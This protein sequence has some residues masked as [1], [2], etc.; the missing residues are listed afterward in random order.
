MLPDQSQIYSLTRRITWVLI[1]AMGCALGISYWAAGLSIDTSGAGYALITIAVLL[2]ISLYYRKFRVDAF[3]STGAEASFQLTAILGMGT[4]LTFAAAAVG[5]PYRDTVLTEVDRSMG[6]NWRAYLDFFNTHYVI[7]HILHVIYLSIHFQPLLVVG[8]L[9]ATRRFLR[10]RQFILAM[11]V[12]LCVSVAIFVF[13]PAVANYA[14]LGLERSDFANL[15]PTCAFEHIRHLEAMRH[16]TTH[17]VRLND[18]EGLIIFPSFHAVAA[19]L[20]TW[21][22]WPVPRLR[23]PIGL[24]DFLMLVA[25]P[26]DG[27]HYA[28]DIVAGGAIAMISVLA[29]VRGPLSLSRTTDA[30]PDTVPAPA[31]SD[32]DATRLRSERRLLL[33]QPRD[34]TPTLATMSAPP[35]PRRAHRET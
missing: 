35:R 17:I 2:L 16:A 12:S 34:M 10:L 14:H 21:A 13:T 25:T 8:T 15:W 19:L 24:L 9:V 27:A 4:L 33:L 6:F 11:G 32:R 31:F 29:A 30:V 3:I 7:G 26:V 23:W 22:L 5:F 1:A 20:F 28:I 18:L